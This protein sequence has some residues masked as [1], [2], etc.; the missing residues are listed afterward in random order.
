MEVIGQGF[1]L[2]LEDMAITNDDVDIYARWLFEHNLRPLAVI[3]EGLEQEFYQIIFHQFS[4]LFQPRIARVNNGA[5]NTATT[6]PISMQSTQGGAGSATKNSSFHITMLP[7]NAHNNLGMPFT[8]NL[9]PHSSTNNSSN[10]Q[11]AL[12]ET[13]SQLVHRH[14]ELCKKTLKVFAMAGRTLKLSGET[15]S[16][17]LKVMLGITDYLLKEPLGDTSNLGVMNMADELCDS[18]LQVLF[19]LWLRS[20]IMDV[21]MWDILKSCFMRWTHRS[22]TIQQWSSTSLALTKRIQNLIYG[23]KEGTDGV[24]VNSPNIKLDLPTEFV[25]YAWH[26]V[27]Y[28]IPHPLQLPSN[29]FTLAI[30][31]IGNLVD[32]LNSSSSG[33]DISHH[34]PSAATN[35]DGNTLLHMFGTYLFDATSKSILIN[36]DTQRGCAESFATLC[37]IFCRPQK[38]EPFLRTYIER[39]YAALKVGLRSEACLPTILLSC[40][41]LFA[42]DLEGVRMLVPDFISAIKMVLPKLRFECRTNVS[43]DNLR[44]AAIKVLSTIMCVPNHFDK[45]ELQLWK[46]GEMGSFVAE[47]IA[48]VGEQ[49]QLITQL[50]RVLYVSP[51]EDSAERPFLSLKFYILEILLMSLRTETSSYNM[52]YI[53]HLI[54]VYVNEDVPFC[55]GLVGTVVKLIQDKILTMQLPADV[56]LVA[57]DVLMDFVDLYD[58]VKRDSKNVARELVLA[59]SRYV[60]ILINAEKLAQTYPLIV[61]AYDCMIKWVLVSQ[62]IV[63]DRDCYKAVIATLSKGITIFERDAPS[64][65][66]EPVNVEKKKRRDTAFP[67]TKQLFQLPPRVNKGIHQ[68]HTTQDQNAAAT[69]ANARGGSTTHKKEQVAVRMAAE[70]C[71]S[72]FVNQLGRFASPHEHVLG[73]Y[74]SAKADDISQLKQIRAQ[75]EQNWAA[76]STYIRYFLIDKRT[77]LTIIDVTDPSPTKDGPGNVPSIIVVIRDTTGKYVWSMETQYVDSSDKKP[78]VESPTKNVASDYLQLPSIDDTGS[79][80]SPQPSPPV[81]RQAAVVPTAVAVNEQE[82]PSIDKVFLPQSSEWNQ[83]EMVK[84]LM[85]KQEASERDNVKQDKDALVNYQI[86]PA[87]ANID[88]NSPR[89]F[90]L[91]LSQAGFLLPMNRSHITPLRIT[92]SMISEMETLDMLNERDCISISAY[93]AKSGR[94]TWSE[95]IETPPALSGQFLQFINCLG[96]PVKTHQH[97]GYRGKLDPSICE[98][99]PYYSDRTVE[100]IVNVP[101]FLKKPAADT[102]EWGNMNT[103]SKI[104][105]QIS[106]DDHV[107]VIWIEDLAQYK[108]L[109]SLIKSSSS[110]NSKAMVYIFINPL[111]HSANG[112]YWVRILVPTQGNSSASLLA[113]QR[114]NENALIFG[115]LVD[116]I[117][118]S[119]HALGSMVRSTAISA[120]QACR[121]VTDTYTRP[122]VIRKEYLEEM[123]H[124]HRIKLPLSEFYSDVFAERES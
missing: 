15:W 22:K 56:T 25:S 114:L 81:Q 77:L 78:A 122:F 82:M 17:L 79:L 105:K 16:V 36:P 84:I 74:R 5:P 8:P 88:L 30:L 83:W 19:E 12:K 96:W 27:L 60:D 97:K 55:P 40:T 57:F 26:R 7:V 99:I 4:L 9:P 28:L 92:D 108:A 21:E 121:V 120:H 65:P 80:S 59:L 48:F 107:C 42:T 66:V 72:Q 124:R 52:R 31:G 93:Y 70:Y 118:V 115:P 23:D 113:S 38:R 104:H 14:V 37:K 101:Y 29:N 13:L 46:G 112:L 3:E 49:E 63:D 64:A 50:I 44:L 47:N 98:T 87:G 103:I 32:T 54:N 2:P 62:W 89:G 102:M 39:Y 20:N 123:A 67:P 45:V 94:V 76:E 11:S 1:N 34:E 24:Y 10:A 58:F 51:A 33:A 85:G 41:E 86:A 35:P 117:V 90:R 71:M 119:R 61:Q 53:L 110:A 73:G 43:I 111:E 95:L 68:H 91:L 106:S 116:G 18:L 75:D 100:F 6:P 109:A 69:N